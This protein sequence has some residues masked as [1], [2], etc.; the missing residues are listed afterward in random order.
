MAVSAYA[1]RAFA[2][3]DLV[4]SRRNNY[5]RGLINGQRGTV[6]AVDPAAGTLTVQLGKTTTTVPAAYLASG[7]LDH[8][9]ALT[10]H[11]S[12]GMT[13][14]QAMLLGFDALYREAGYVGLPVA[15]SATT[16]T[17]S[18]GLSATIPPSRTATRRSAPRRRSRTPSPPY[19]R[20]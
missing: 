12:Q 5:S 11:Q 7:G 4:I 20:R 17:W 10:V 14:D 9:Y 6:T 1:D 8:G 3:G 2:A 13:C 16:C 15:G 19:A 18:T